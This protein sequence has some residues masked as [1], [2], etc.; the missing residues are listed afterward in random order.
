MYLFF[1]NSTIMNVM[2]FDPSFSFFSLSPSLSVK[3]YFQVFLFLW[4]P[5]HFIRIAC[6]SIS[7]GSFTGVKTMN[8]WGI[9]GPSL[10]KLS[11]SPLWGLSTTHP[12]VQEGWWAPHLVLVFSK[13]L[14]LLW[15][16][17]EENRAL[18]PWQRNITKCLIFCAKEERCY[19]LDS[20]RR[21]K[22]R[23][24]QK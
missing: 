20:S 19:W 1:H 17:G 16:R 8:Q 21:W 7:M 3:P 14:L 22:K 18:Q 12:S 6:M 10:R 24:K 9:R 13:C 4:W 23:S 15:F 11:I 2:S 5:L